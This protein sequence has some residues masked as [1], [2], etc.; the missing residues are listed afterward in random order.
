MAWQFDPIGHVAVEMQIMA[1]KC[2]E[3][4]SYRRRPQR[5]QQ[6]WRASPKLAATPA[7]PMPPDK[8]RIFQEHL[9]N[10]IARFPEWR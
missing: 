8:A 4:K 6:P 1:I 5:A 7:D 9:A 10:Y 3:A 2:D